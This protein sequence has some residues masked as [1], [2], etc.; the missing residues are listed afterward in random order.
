MRQEAVQ[1]LANDMLGEQGNLPLTKPK[2]WV[3]RDMVCLIR[4]S[5]GNVVNILKNFEGEQNEELNKQ[6][7][8]LKWNSEVKVHIDYLKIVLEFLKKAKI[9][10][11]KIKASSDYPLCFEIK[12]ECMGTTEI[13]IAPRVG[14]D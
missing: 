9:E 10:E 7:Q 8:N 2:A 3:T 14:S 13:I 4:S 1:K 11:V 12:E 6:T 5:N